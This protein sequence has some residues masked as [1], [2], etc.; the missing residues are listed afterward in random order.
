ML[1]GIRQ[2]LLHDPVGGEV[3]GTRQRE[4]LSLH[5]EQDG[6]TG[7]RDL[8]DQRVEAVDARLRREVGAVALGPHGA[9][10]T[11]HL[12]KC[13]AARL[14]DV[15]ER[16]LVLLQRVRQLVSH[17]PDLKHHDADRVRDDVVELASDARALL[18]D[19][20]ARGHLSLSLGLRRTRLRRFRLLRPL[21]QSKAGK[22]AHSEQEGVEDELPDRVRRQVVENDRGTAEHDDQ[23]HPRVSSVP[24]AP[25]QERGCHP[26][27]EDGEQER[28][29][30]S[31]DERDADSD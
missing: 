22:P 12:R 28:D 9:E 30:P 21:M 3:D 18:G 8:L 16:V 31:V 1:E 13:R 20:D 24:Q 4:A 19:G 17:R 6:Q 25:E 7:P 11:A 5:V 23:A 26:D 10:E 14:L 15:P 2:S 29:E 27:D